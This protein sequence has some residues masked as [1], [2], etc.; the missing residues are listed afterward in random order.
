[1]IGEGTPLRAF[2]DLRAWLRGIR[3]LGLDFRKTQNEVP[4]PT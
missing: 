1:V 3:R 2:L 4:S